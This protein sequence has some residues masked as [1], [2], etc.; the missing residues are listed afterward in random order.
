MLLF[1]FE[2]EGKYSLLCCHR[3]LN[4]FDKIVVF[5]VLCNEYLNQRKIVVNQFQVPNDNY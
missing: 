5:L 1:T 4:L 2:R 3:L